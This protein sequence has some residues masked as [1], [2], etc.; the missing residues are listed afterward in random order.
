M[1]GT[2][3]KIVPLTNEPATEESWKSGM[4][5]LSGLISR[6]QLANLAGLQYG[7]D[8]NFYTIFGYKVRLTPDDFLAKYTRQDIA[9]R[10]VDAPPNATW[11][12]PPTIKDNDDLMEEWKKLAKPVNLWGA[13][14]RA[15]KLA[16]LNPFSILLFGFADGN[17]LDTPTR[18]SVKQLAYV[19]AIGSRQVEEV[20]FDVD[21]KSPRFGLAVSYKIKFDDPVSRAATGG[22]ISKG[23]LLSV[24]VHWSRVVH[25]VE[26]PLEDMVFGNP[27]MERVYN[28][29]DDLMKVAGGTAEMFWLGGRGGIQADIDKDMT[30]DPADAKDLSDEIKDY[31]HQLTRFIRTRGVKLSTLDTSVPAPKEV[32]EMIMALISGTTG[33]PRRILL[34]SEAGQLASEQDRAN[35]AERIT[36]RRALYA[37][38][39]ILDPTTLLLQNV[40]LLS[41]GDAEWEWPSAFIQNPLEESQ[42]MAQKAR[43]TG[44]LSRQTGNATPM[45]VTSRPEAREILGLE[46][47]LSDADLLVPIK[48]ESAEDDEDEPGEDVRQRIKDID[49]DQ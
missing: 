17:K 22:T 38:P 18:D 34:G 10:I 21:D 42:V 15:D 36:E 23:G 2:D 25:V 8:R 14:N 24:N 45:Q 4:Q 43:A 6:L 32:F 12:N 33:I 35:W 27:I 3:N 31:M 20:K 26:N 47:D 28:L 13:M 44:N 5:T 16:R 29:L 41:E 40:G 19:R 7:G 37:T 9:S 1:A 48:S 11:S 49:A 30:I 39:H 46:G